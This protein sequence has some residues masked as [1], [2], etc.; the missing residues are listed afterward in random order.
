MESIALSDRDTKLERIALSDQ[1][2]I[3]L[4][5]SLNNLDSP[6]DDL[7][8][9]LISIYPVFGG[10]PRQLLRTL[11]EFRNDPNAYGALLLQNFPIDDDLPATPS[12]SRRS[13]DKKTFVS[14][15]S[16]LGI[17]QILGQPIGYRDEKQGEIIQTLS[18]VKKEAHATSSESSEVD[19]GFHTDFSFDRD[20]PDQPYN[21]GNADYIVL[22]CLR[23][24]RKGEAYTLYAD[25]RDIC[26][27]LTTAQLSIARKPLFQ[28]AA[29]YSFTGA[30]GEERIWSAPCPLIKGPDRFPEVSVDLLCGVRGVNQEADNV[31][32]S[33]REVCELPG[34]A[35]RVCLEPGELLLMDNRKGAHARTAF[36][37]Y[38]DGHD[39]WLQRL[40]ARRSL[41]EIRRA[42]SEALRVF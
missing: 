34:V 13:N 39:R 16:L 32:D 27:Y 9:F 19:L 24:D 18:P 2:K 12:D 33:L 36:A 35:S 1:D 22:L 26:K 17:A 8:E 23:R 30:C 28:F 25:A 21:V 14:E 29:S 5:S 42:S 6:Y 37:A 10:L 20:N 4:R 15:A 40:Y 41:W 3:R 38:F 11:F 31:L 7:E